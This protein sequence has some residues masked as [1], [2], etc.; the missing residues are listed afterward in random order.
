VTAVRDRTRRAG[1][2]LRARAAGAALLAALTLVALTLAGCGTAGYGAPVAPRPM[3]VSS[4]AFVSG[5]L[6]QRYTCPRARN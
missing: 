4:A 3:P 2:P 6:A 5:I 1:R